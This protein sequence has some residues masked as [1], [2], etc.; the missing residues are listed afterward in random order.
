MAVANQ[1]TESNVVLVAGHYCSSASI[2]ASKVYAKSNMVQISPGST[3]PALTDDRAGPNIYRVC[4][5]DDQ[6]GSVAGKY[7]AKN[8]ADK[9]IA[10]VND[11]NAYGKGLAEETKKALNAAG[12]QEL[13][14]GTYATGQRDY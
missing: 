5:R 4:G 9:N 7:L 11:Q 13:M 8:F 2:A 14:Y 12:K 10:I 6:Q 1:M 3:N